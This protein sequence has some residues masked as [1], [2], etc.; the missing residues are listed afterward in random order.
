[1][2]ANKYALL[3]YRIIDRCLTNAGK[4]YPNK[5]ILRQACEDALY[6]SFGENISE[7]TIEKDLWAMRNESELG[8]YAPIAYHRIEKGYYYE[9]PEY[10]I[11]NIS[12]NQ[13]DID[14]LTLATSTLYQFRN[15]PLFKQ[16]EH[17]I[18]KI[19]AR[20]SIKPDANDHT[21]DAF[22]Q[23]EE[24]PEVKGIEFLGPLLQA[25]QTHSN[26]SFS[27]EKFSVDDNPELETRTTN[28]YLLKEYRNRWYLIGWDLE[29]NGFRTYGLD[30]ISELHVLNETFEPDPTFDP[31]RF[32]IHSIGITEIDTTPT[33]VEFSCSL[34]LAK[35][36]AS[37]PLHHS[38]QIKKKGKL[39]Y[40][41][42]RVLITYELLSILRSYGKDIE[43]TKPESLRKRMKDDLE[44]TLKQ[45]STT[46]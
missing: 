46:P 43:V 28:P 13:D 27:Y 31:A 38:Q 12:L 35:Y 40:I 11:N 33:D 24:A 44:F 42:L 10:S 17:A 8:Y 32:F 37:Q 18:E 6:G 16:Y 9:D 25:I 15:T 20:I 45:Y 21:A 26:V 19:V 14:A 2:P 4:P 30:R 23:F 29:K 41:Q 34:L 1:M 7:S 3:R 39:V 22:I 5:E 36:L